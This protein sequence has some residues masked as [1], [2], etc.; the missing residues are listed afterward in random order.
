MDQSARKPRRMARSAMV[1]AALWAAGVCMAAPPAPV[2]QP[3]ATNRC[4]SELSPEALDR[5]AGR[6][7]EQPVDLGADTAADPLTVLRS[8]A[9]QAVQ[10]S[11]TVGASRLLN[12][13]ATFDLEQARSSR[14]PALVANAALGPQHS[15]LNDETSTKGTLRSLSFSASGS[16]Y[17]A[18]RIREQVQWREELLQAES[19]GLQQAGESV[20]AEVVSG[21]LERHRY[22]MQ[23]QVY[24]QYVRKMQ[25]L[26][27]ALEV[28]VSADRGRASELVQA[29]KT[30]AQA[31]MQR[32]IAAAVGKQIDIKLRKLLGEGQVPSG[33]LTGALAATPELNEVRRGVT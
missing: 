29:R 30:L 8:V 7:S 9:R 27:D 4:K 23:A 31:E 15:T 22:Q 14:W 33:R 28:I 21:M 13:A 10:R 2:A 25:C 16:L 26:L 5:A 18:G 11:A 1:G 19:L 3:Q 24:Q 20:V 6:N 12:E 32:D 17:D